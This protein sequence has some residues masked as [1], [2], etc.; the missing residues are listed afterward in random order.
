MIA[1]LRNR[2]G[3]AFLALALAAGLSVAGAPSAPAA[4]A[5][6]ERCPD[7][8]SCYFSGANGTGDL[9]KAPNPGCFDL[10]HWNPPFNDRISSVF[11][12]GGHEVHM[13]DW[14][15][16]YWKWVADVQI[17]EQWSVNGGGDPR[18]D[19]IDAVCVGRTP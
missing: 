13:Y 15:G 17:G 9:W 10:G 3:G 1:A 5:G 16:T 11:N 4:A 8:Y 6:Y 12:R 18:N 7:R 2:A 19:V 14:T